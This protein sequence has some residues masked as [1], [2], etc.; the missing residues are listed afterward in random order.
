MKNLFVLLLI[1]TVLMGCPGKDDPVDEVEIKLK[2]GLANGEWS[3]A[4]TAGG[5]DNYTSYKNFHYTFEVAEAN[6]VVS[7][8]LISGDINVQ[9]TLFDPI[10][11]RVET[12]T[13]GRQISSPYTAKSPGIYRIVVSADRRA[14]G[15]FSLKVTGTKAGIEPVSFQALRSET[16]NWGPLGGGAGKKTFKNHFYTFEVVEDNS[17]IDIEL[18][19]ADTE[20][21]LFLYDNL[22]ALVTARQSSRYEYILYAVKKGVYTVMAGTN[23]RGSVGNYNLHIFGKTKNLKRVSSSSE[24]KS[25]KWNAGKI[26]EILHIYSIDITSDANSP[27]DIELASPDVNVVIELQ[28]KSGDNIGGIYGAQKSQFYL[29][30]DLPKGSYRIQVRP[31]GTLGGS[32][33]GGKYGLT[34]AGQ[35][36]NL[37]KM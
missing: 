21:S 31:S 30:K 33:S 2:D 24:T 13:Q 29:S 16:Q 1:A 5:F 25:E 26:G 32:T 27:L 19:S 23:S 28:D 36:A 18:L 3:S 22:G 20:V 10:G 14:I 34:V 9:Y 8:E 17:A 4:S 7:F 12:S 35:F 11:N 6:Q 15:K 37:K